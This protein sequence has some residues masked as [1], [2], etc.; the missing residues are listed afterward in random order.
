MFSLCQTLSQPQ[1]AWG[2]IRKRTYR[3]DK[4]WEKNLWKME[5]APSH[6]EEDEK[7]RHQAKEPLGLPEGKAQNGVREELRLQGGVQ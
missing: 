4:I 5:M 1:A 3:A 7:G 6:G 2:D